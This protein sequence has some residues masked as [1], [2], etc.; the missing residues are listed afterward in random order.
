LQFSPIELTFLGR[1]ESNDELDAFTYEAFAQQ[2]AWKEASVAE[3]KQR[4]DTA[5]LTPDELLSYDLWIY[6]LEKMQASEPFFYDG[7]IFDQMNGIQS[8]VPTFLIN[9]HRVDTQQD[10][11]AY[12]Q[13]VE[14]VAPRMQEAIEIASKGLAKGVISHTF[15]LDGVI[16]Q[17]NKVI[18]GQPFD[19]SSEVDSDLWADIKS[20]ISALQDA[21]TIDGQTAEELTADAKAALLGSFLPAYQNIVQWAENAGDRA[22]EKV[23]GVGA[24]PNGAAYYDYRLKDQTTTDLTADEIHQIGLDEVA[25]LRLEMEQIKD[26][27]Q[28]DGDL[29]TFFAHIRDSDWNYYPDTDE[30]RQAYIDDATAAIERIKSA[31]PDYFGLL[32]QADLIVKRVEPF[33]E[34][35]GA[36]QH[37]YPGTPDGS[38][39][40]IYYAHLLITRGCPGTICRFPLPKNSKKS[41][42]LEPK[43]ALLLIPRAGVC[44]LNIW[45]RKF[46]APTLTLTK[47]LVGL[48]VRFGAPF[49]WSSTPVC[50]P[51]DG[52]SNRPSIT[53]PPIHRNHW[54]A[55]ARKCSAI[56]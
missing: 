30:G 3:M 4:F 16:K 35:D 47:I 33:R 56:S 26:Q 2:L 51:R 24:Q 48:P 8:F 25:R 10:M 18:S 11:E 15:A 44:T 21:G 17:T 22:P 40:G 43:H 5:A 32:P 38:R 23:S 19:P 27:V 50:T 52:V 34:R 31:L 53:S 46:P 9:F 54:K 37:Y 12:I 29:Q 55:F 39:P 41:P 49:D 45:P 6:Q 20:E 36:A 13:R 1:K 28:F 14:A 42:N 7:L